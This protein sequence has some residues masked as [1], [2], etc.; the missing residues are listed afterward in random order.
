MSR[1]DLAAKYGTSKNSGKLINAAIRAE[2]PGGTELLE[3]R[4]WLFQNDGVLQN[5]LGERTVSTLLAR[6][7][8]MHVAMANEIRNRYGMTASDPTDHPPPAGPAAG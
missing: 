6:V 7:E 2:L 8:A 1:Q 4:E 5:G 3:F